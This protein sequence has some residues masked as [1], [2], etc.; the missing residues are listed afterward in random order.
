MTRSF[1][2]DLRYSH[3]HE[4]FWRRHYKQRFPK[5]VS[6]EVRNDP[7]YQ[8]SGIDRIV[9]FGPGR[10]YCWVEEKITDYAPG[11]MAIEV[12]SDVEADRPGWAD[13][14]LRCDY[15]TLGYVEHDVSLWFRWDWF[16]RV[17]NQ[18]R[19]VWV[20]EAEFNKRT[21]QNHKFPKL[22]TSHTEHKG[23]YTASHALILPLDRFPAS[24]TPADSFAV[25]LPASGRTLSYNQ[26]RF[27]VDEAV[28][29][30]RGGIR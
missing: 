15:L 12:K 5:M 22:V 17:W 9:K 25:C 29:E 28:A 30:I 23:R 7:A 24:L 16:K 11:R 3:S 18:Y 20:D 8:L 6:M 4:A 10:Q 27:V 13:R 2:N 1:Q 26:F 19:D 21:L 14:D